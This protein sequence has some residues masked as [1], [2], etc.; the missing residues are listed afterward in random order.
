[1]INTIDPTLDAKNAALFTLL[2]PHRCGDVMQRINLWVVAKTGK[3]LPDYISNGDTLEAKIQL[4]E[5]LTEIVRKQDWSKLPK[6]PNGQVTTSAATVLTPA[7]ASP[8]VPL[9][10]PPADKTPQVI[11]TPAWT[12]LKPAAL[13]A[14]PPTL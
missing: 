5:E 13:S 10:T 12:A 9:P 3:K 14:P 11:P 2:M 4:V 8:V 7:A 1:M 6:V